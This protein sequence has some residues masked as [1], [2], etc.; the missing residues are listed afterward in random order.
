MNVE[1]AHVT[2]PASPRRAAVEAALETKKQE[3]AAHLQALQEEVRQLGYTVREALLAHPLLGLGA[4]LAAGLVVGW[5][6]GGVGQG[7]RN[8]LRR[9]HRALV[10]GYIEALLAEGRKAARQGRN[11]EAAIRQA[12]RERVPVIFVQDARPRTPLLRK[13]GGA[14]FGLLGGAV[15]AAASRVLT[16]VVLQAFEAAVPAASATEDGQDS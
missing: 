10:E 9:A 1:F 11:P 3:M 16:E 7:R 14:A 12:L 8:T 13:L 15:S 2:R 5:L 6:L 4:G